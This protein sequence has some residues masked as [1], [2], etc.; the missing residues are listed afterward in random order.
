[1][2]FDTYGLGD[3][4]LFG[5]GKRM[6]IDNHEDMF[7]V[8]LDNK[9]SCCSFLLYVSKS[10]LDKKL[11][12]KDH[13]TDDEEEEQGSITSEGS[14]FSEKGDRINDQGVQNN[15]RSKLRK[16]YVLQTLND[17]KKRSQ[18]NRSYQ[19]RNKLRSGGKATF[20]DFFINR[21]ER[22]QEQLIFYLTSLYTYLI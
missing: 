6:K 8:F 1:M 7:D 10:Y 13:D 16:K 4:I 17:N 3:V 11:R 14:I 21:F 9:D 19:M 15:R 22:I 5:D 12:K 20:Q 2:E 18:D